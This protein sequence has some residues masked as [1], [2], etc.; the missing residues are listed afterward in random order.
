[1]SR[2]M[3]RDNAPERLENFFPVRVFSVLLLVQPKEL[4]IPTILLSFTNGIP[5]KIKVARHGGEGGRDPFLRCST[6]VAGILYLD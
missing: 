6:G 5:A 4:S 1:M 3:L 2:S